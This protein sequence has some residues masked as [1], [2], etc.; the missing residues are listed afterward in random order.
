M[1]VCPLRGEIEWHAATR[2][3][4]LQRDIAVEGLPT[5]R[6][7]CWPAAIVAESVAE[8]EAVKEEPARRC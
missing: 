1:S 6:L 5:P 4:V 3:A 8:G 7:T 2:L